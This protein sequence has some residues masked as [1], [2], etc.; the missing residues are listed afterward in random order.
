MH[1]YAARL[2]AQ[3][4]RTEFLSRDG[5]AV[6]VA[7]DYWRLSK[8]VAFNLDWL[9][10]F[11]SDDMVLSFRHVLSVYAQTCSSKHAINLHARLK[12]YLRFSAG[13]AVFSP[14]SIISYR[15]K[16]LGEEWKLSGVRAFIRTWVSTGY[17][18]I[19]SETLPMMEKWRIKGNEK[20]FAVQSMCPE[21]GPLT[22]IEMD[23]IVSGVL[24]CYSNGQLDLRDTCYAMILAMTGRRSIQITSL[25]NKD[26]LS[27]GDKY[28]INFP[29]GK[30]RYGKWRTAFKKFPIVEDLW[31]LLQTQAERVKALFNER[32][33]GGVSLELVRELP[34]FPAI[35]KYDASKSLEE[36]LSGDFLHAPTSA[37]TYA[38]NT[39]KSQVAVIS[40]RTGAITHMNP[41]RFRYTLGTNLAREGK[42]EYVIAEA[43]DHSDTQNASVY[44]RNIPEFVEQIDKAVALQLA[45]LAQ[46]FR[47]VLVVNEAAAHRGGD[48][49]SR[50]YSSGGNV[51]SCGSFGFC[52][53]LAPVACYT[54][55]HFQPWLE[56]PHE[57]V[58]DQLISERDSVLQATGDPKV[59]SVNDRLILAVSD[60]VTRC[61]AMKSEPVHV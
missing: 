44:V 28:Y 24:E 23:G 42:G 15:A 12:E 1:G 43:L 49:T 50:I 33:S 34:L 26:L 55:A 10:E 60:V 52:G 54:C 29:R 41:T 58:L 21:S 19:P 46:A 11:L 31:L 18:G 56:G 22:D 57:L 59:A 17:K 25:K 38:M 47:G 5:Y 9:C 36:L 39:V 32:V 45:P 8:D 51:G 35:E 6:V 4:E 16:L 27:V 7:S 13:Q 61:N 40:E 2:P 30:Q 48:P 53:A 3:Y 14:E 20:G 37:I